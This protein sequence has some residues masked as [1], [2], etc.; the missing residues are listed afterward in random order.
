MSPHSR[1]QRSATDVHLP[2]AGER[3]ASRGW[4]GR[5]HTR[6]P[7]EAG[8]EESRSMSIF[9]CD[10]QSPSSAGITRR[11]N[12]RARCGRFCSS[13]AHTPDAAH[14]RQLRRAARG[15]AALVAHALHLL[16]LEVR[17]RLGAFHGAHRPPRPAE[18]AVRPSAPEWQNDGRGPRA[19]ARC[20]TEATPPPSVTLHP[21]AWRPGA[22]RCA[23][24]RPSKSHVSSANS[25]DAWP[26]GP[27]LTR[28]SL[29]RARTGQGR[30]RAAE[31][32]RAL[33]HAS[34]NVLFHRAILLSG[35]PAHHHPPLY[36][37]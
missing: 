9:S 29:R 14:R 10:L 16:L 23:P 4:L 11:T 3:G 18:R 7:D 5:K 13:R 36:G 6:L 2:G 12:G 25:V 19:P 15:A 33:V 27:F 32:A 28:R 1:A 8:G 30:A 21:A 35:H 37:I 34:R 22:P 31:T 20:C 24:P 26:Y 17:Q